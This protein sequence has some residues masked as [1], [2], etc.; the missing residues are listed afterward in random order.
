M[1]KKSFVIMDKSSV[2]IDPRAKIGEN[3]IIYENNRI[4]GNSE[5]GDNVTLYP[6]N[7]IQDTK[8]GKGSKVHASV[9]EGSE[10]GSCT[11]IGP[12][13]HLRVGSKIGSHV[14]I[15]N[16]CEIKN[17]EIGER[18]K[19]SHL[20]YVGDAK[21]GKNC[22][23]GCGV[24]FVNYN[25]K[26]KQTTYVEDGV[27]IGS[28]VN[29]IAPVKVGKGAYI[30]AGTTIADNISAGDFVIGRCR[31]EVKPGRASDYLL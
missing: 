3:V 25:G 31:A 11:T 7:F 21:V 16:F 13:A 26:I 14:K 9:L 5:I 10:V 18:T 17:A 30:C 28:N 12:F 23:I 20:S 24:V 4:E 27:F 15:G 29:I 19:I 8:I 2:F 1:K 6:N 22:N